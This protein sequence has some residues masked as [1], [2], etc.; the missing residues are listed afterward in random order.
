MSSSYHNY[1]ARRAAGKFSCRTYL[2]LVAI[3]FGLAKILLMDKPD[4]YP[5]GRTNLQRVVRSRYMNNLL[6][7][8]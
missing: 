8:R 4:M 2:T 7:G 1:Y 3:S 6:I 5:D